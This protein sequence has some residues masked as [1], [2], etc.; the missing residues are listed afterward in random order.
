MVLSHAFPGKDS[1]L[2]AVVTILK[3]QSSS[4]NFDLWGID[5]I[6]V[7]TLT[8]T[9]AG[10]TS[11]KSIIRLQRDTLIM[12]RPSFSQLTT[13]PPLR[14]YTY[15]TG[16]LTGYNQQ[17]WSPVS[18]TITSSNPTVVA[19]DSGATTN[20][21][22]D[23]ATTLV[24][25]AHYGGYVRL[26]FKQPGTAYLKASAPGWAGDS[27]GPF[28][29]TGPSLF[30]T[31]TANTAGVGQ[32][33]F[34]N[35]YVTN[36]VSSPLVVTFQRSDSLPIGGASN[37]FNFNPIQVTIPAGSTSAAINDTLFG[38]TIGT[39]QLIARATGYGTATATIQIGKP[40]LVSQSTLSLSVGAAPS[41]VNV[42]TTDQTTNTRYVSTPVTVTA[43]VS[44]PTV[45]AVDSATRVIS[46]GSYTLASLFK[47]S[48][49]KKG[50]CRRSSRRPGTSPTR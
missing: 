8:A 40:Q 17:P 35:V 44:D 19:I 22:Q 1:V 20:G 21:T 43:T 13:S 5:S 12:Q 27:I 33:T 42:S 48:G 25:T 26:V 28:T 4:N 32:M 7:D 15:L 30:L 34:E 45:A 24:D 14:L 41:G 6:G 37:V 29:V 38:D 47:F 16:Q 39:A 11:A 46:T 9:S 10:F 23:T 3:G 31:P 50:P 2:P 49:L 18:I 36:P